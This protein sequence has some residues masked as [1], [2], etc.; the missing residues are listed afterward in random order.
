MPAIVVD[1]FGADL[2]FRL[3]TNRP[4]LT[5]SQNLIISP[6]RLTT[7]RAF[8]YTPGTKSARSTQ[9][10]TISEEEAQYINLDFSPR[11]FLV[12]KYGHFGKF[13]CTR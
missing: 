2:I 8:A 12:R 7:K 3:L 6:K 5:H 10:V 13:D 11:V 4:R 9:L 1:P